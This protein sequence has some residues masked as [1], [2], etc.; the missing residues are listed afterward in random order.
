[1]PRGRKE[2][3]TRKGEEGEE[4]GRIFRCRCRAS[5]RQDRL[6]DTQVIRISD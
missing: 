4:E 1:M 3:A 5:V 6:R 2:G